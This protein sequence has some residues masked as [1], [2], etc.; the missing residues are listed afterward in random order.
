MGLKARSEQDAIDGALGD[1]AKR[2]SGCHVIA[3][4]SYAVRP[5]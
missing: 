3:I 1:C 5:N 2:D 4:G